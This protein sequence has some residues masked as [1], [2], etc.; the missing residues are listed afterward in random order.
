MKHDLKKR[1]GSGMLMLDLGSSK[2]DEYG[3]KAV[4]N[5]KSSKVNSKKCGSAK[6]VMRMNLRSKGMDSNNK[7]FLNLKT[8]KEDSKGRHYMKLGG[9]N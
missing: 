3:L 6:G 5:S 9:N 1:A 7:L 2:E 4:T 8:K